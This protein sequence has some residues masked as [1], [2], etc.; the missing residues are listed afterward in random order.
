M[1]N[2]RKLSTAIATGA[3]LLSSVAPAFAS[4]VEVSGNGAFSGNTVTQSNT[5]TTSVSQNNTANVTNNVDSNASTGG[6]SAG[7]N[8]GGNTTID[9]GDASNNVDVSTAVNLN[10]ASVG[11]GCAA[12]GTDV[13]I[14]GNGA[15]STNAADV[16]NSS[17]T[18]LSQTNDAHIRNDIDANAKTGY[19]DAGFNT[20][21]NTTIRTGDASSTVSV[22]NKA[23]ANFANVGGSSAGGA[24]GSSIIISG[25]GAFSG[26]TASLDRSAVVALTQDNDAHIRNDVD[27]N[28]KTGDNSAGFNT[29]GDVRVLT[30]DATTDV[31]V[32]NMVNFNAADVDCGCV[33][34]G[35]DIKIAGNGAYSD[36]DVS[37]SDDN[38]VAAS[39]LNDA[40][41]HN[42]VDGKAKT[43]DNDA[44]FNTASVHGDPTV[45]TG[46]ASSSTDVSNTGNVNIFDQGA[47]L[48]LPGNWELG[49]HFDLMGLW[50]GLLSWVS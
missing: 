3:V 43:G 32:D 28:A 19:N 41:L 46:D 50:G 47:T 8:T 11:C 31:M 17:T 27:A 26:N 37:A 30:G 42:D 18:A 24:G 45:R 10:K 13:K 6:N 29:G 16:T 34:D 14:S 40:Y 20:G 7:F 1:T 33:L 35:T 21:G 48:G 39:A 9:T 23:N 36:S 4:T 49:L 5:N 38:I 2:F 15:F 25:N 12:D 44:G 22:D